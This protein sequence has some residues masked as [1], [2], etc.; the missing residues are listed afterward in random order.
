MIGIGLSDEKDITVKGLEAVNGSKAIY[1]E[2]YTSIL[3]C[4]KEDLE[5][6]YGKKITLANREFT[7][8]QTQ[9]IIKEAKENNVAFL[10]IGAPLAATTHIDIY[11]QAKKAKVEVEV[12]ENASVLT[13]IGITG[14]F[15]YKFGRV[16]T[17]PLENEN[18][19]SPYE[20]LKQNKKQELHTLL[21]LDIKTD[22]LMTAREGLDYL[23]KQGLNPEEQVIVCGGLGTKKPEIK[24][25]KAKEVAIEKKPQSIIIPGK[26]HFTEEEALELYR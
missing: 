17:I 15:L 5:T 4:T 19:T 14:L 21:L 16:T 10:V 6:Y 13:A 26:L 11:L 12:I 22:T 20:V 8:T 9:K 3:Q 25:G 23:I 2:N 18:I 1:L 24:V 7:E